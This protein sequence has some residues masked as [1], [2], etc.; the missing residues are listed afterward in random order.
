MI[1]SILIFKYEGLGKDGKYYDSGEVKPELKGV[2]GI[3][4][5]LAFAI[6]GGFFPVMALGLLFGIK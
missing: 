4:T 5:R 6:F 1:S 3:V 2:Y